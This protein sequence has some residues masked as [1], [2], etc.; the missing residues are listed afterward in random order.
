MTVIVIIIQS[1]CVHKYINVAMQHLEQE[2]EK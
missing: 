1:A 2:G